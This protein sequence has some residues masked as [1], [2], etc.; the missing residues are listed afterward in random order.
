MIDC[1]ALDPLFCAPAACEQ[2]PD[3]YGDYRL[4]VASPCLPGHNPCGALIGVEGQGCGTVL[5]IP[6]SW[7]A[8]KA[9]F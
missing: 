5:A 2:A 7:G 9:M 8:V 3:T 4:D 6:M 1:I